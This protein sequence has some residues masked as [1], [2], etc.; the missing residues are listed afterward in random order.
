MVSSLRSCSV[1]SWPPATRSTRASA[2]PTPRQLGG[3]A[4][5]IPIGAGSAKPR[6]GTSSPR[7]PTIRSTM[8]ERPTT[9]ASRRRVSRSPSPVS[10][11]VPTSAGDSA[12]AWVCTDACVG[13]CPAP[14]GGL[15]VKFS[16]S[17]FPFV[18]TVKDDGE[19]DAG[20]WQVAKVNL[21]FLAPVIPWS[22]V[23]WWCPFYIEM[24]LGLIG[25]SLT[26]PC[27]RSQR[28]DYGGRCARHGLLTQAMGLLRPI[29]PSD[30]GVIQ[31]QVSEAR[32]QGGKVMITRSELLDVVYRFYPRGVRNCGASMCLRRALLRRH[33][34][35][36]PL[37]EAAER[38]RTEYPTWKAMIRRLGD[39][40]RL[41]NES[42]SL[43]GM[44]ADP[45]SRRAS[46]SPTKR[47]SASTCAC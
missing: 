39:R 44:G 22:V 21:Q 42:L 23:T 41:Q 11:E 18:T 27:C 45:A 24:P 8:A 38:G 26:K 17:D 7:P 15:Y 40:Y 35:A 47:R 37:V 36:P 34:G 43:F 6:P 29:Y 13:K 2:G 5:T 28:R 10:C 25:E 19:G 1:C 16:P 46:G 33:R 20:G 3:G 31:V 9:P 12:T 32:R 4:E 30:T 14:G